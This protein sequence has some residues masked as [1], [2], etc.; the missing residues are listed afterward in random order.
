MN[1]RVNTGNSDF[2]DNRSDISM[3][4]LIL[5]STTSALALKG[6]FLGVLGG[7]G[8]FFGGGV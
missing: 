7:L 4:D 1:T 3:T 2:P 5:T 8:V 6:F